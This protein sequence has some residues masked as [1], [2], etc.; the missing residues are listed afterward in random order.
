MSEFLYLALLLTKLPIIFFSF[1][2]RSKENPGRP[3]RDPVLHL[4]SPTPF[5]VSL[6]SSHQKL[7]TCT[8]RGFAPGSRRITVGLPIPSSQL[9]FLPLPSFIIGFLADSASSPQRFLSPRSIIARP[10]T[11]DSSP[12]DF[13]PSQAYFPP[14]I[15]LVDRKNPSLSVP[16]DH[17]AVYVSARPVHRVQTPLQ[18][19]YISHTAET[20]QSRHLFLRL[21]RSSSPE[22]MP[23]LLQTRPCPVCPMSSTSP[24]L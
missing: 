7:C 13:H 9:R 14:S 8:T 19:A 23:A 12:P 5:L 6:L 22:L 18:A 3:K 11:T 17:I 10:E 2:L 15:V 16:A 4:S 20:L 1:T 24:H 21:N